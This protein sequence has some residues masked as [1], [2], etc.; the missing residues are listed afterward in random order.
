MRSARARKGW[1]FEW[2]IV[3]FAMG[4]A[5][6]TAAAADLEGLGDEDVALR[7]GV[8]THGRRSDRSQS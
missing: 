3:V 1:A 4:T 2:W 8:C 5:A 7:D 6:L